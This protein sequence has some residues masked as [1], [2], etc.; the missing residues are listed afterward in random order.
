MN[1][2]V[3]RGLVG[4]DIGAANIKCALG[5]LDQRA[6]LI[7]IIAT[8]SVPTMGLREGKVTD[9]KALTRAINEGVNRVKNHGQCE[10]DQLM[11]SISS[12]YFYTLDTA[13]TV[14]ISEG[15]VT[16]RDVLD[17]VRACHEDALHAQA[18]Q[19]GYGITHTLPQQYLLDHQ[20][21]D[22]PPWSQPALHLGLKAHLVYG[23]RD[24]MNTIWRLKRDLDATRLE[25]VVVDLLAQSEGVLNPDEPSECA[26][27]LD[28]GSET[29][30]VLLLRKGKPVFLF[31][32]LQGG[33]HLTNEIQRQLKIRDFD[34]AEQL[35]IRYGQVYV[36]AHERSEPRIP[37]ETEGP[38]RYIRQESLAR[39]LERALTENLSALRVR[40]EEAGVA[41]L[42]EGGVILT[43][44][45]ANIP[46][47]CTLAGDIL[48]TKV[49]LGVPQQNGVKDLVQAPQYATVNGLVVAGFKRRFNHWFSV[50]SRDLKD[51]PNPLVKPK[52]R[53]DSLW[54]QIKSI[55]SNNAS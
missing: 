15:R 36:D 38:R 31:N 39:I 47:I 45:T 20:A 52:R 49:T 34:D 44:G 21:I 35:K 16:H 46:G 54:S 18:A 8:S 4:V 3:E 51:I 32:R 12:R 37:L 25:D 41:D 50:W 48:Q 9:I 10:I 23:H 17:A 28:I 55:W 26:A 42:L 6:D 11:I 14:D 1:S 5:I 24:T 33:V 40:L 19:G 2:Q 29:T 27:V 22:V 43:G 30:K 53:R 13:S 7:D